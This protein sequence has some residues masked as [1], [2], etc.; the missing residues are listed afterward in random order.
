MGTVGAPPDGA[1][2]MATAAARGA[3]AV[4]SSDDGVQRLFDDDGRDVEQTVD[5]A[6]ANQDDEKVHD[7]VDD[8]T[9]GVRRPLVDDVIAETDR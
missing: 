2:A 7:S 8:V 3:W 6:A 1:V 4:E 5:D 9:A